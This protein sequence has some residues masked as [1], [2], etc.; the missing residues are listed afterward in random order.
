MLALNPSSDHGVKLSRG[1]PRAPLGRW[2]RAYSPKISRFC[3]CLTAYTVPIPSWLEP[4]ATLP[5]KRLC[6][7]ENLSSIGAGEMGEVYA[8]YDTVWTESSAS[9]VLPS[10][11]ADNP[12]Q[13]D[14]EA[15]AIFVAQA[16]APLHADGIL[17]GE[18]PASRLERCHCGSI[19]G[20]V[21]HRGR[22][23]IGQGLPD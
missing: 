13:F 2:T 7:Y 21:R 11:L 15:R 19:G 12:E 8:A 9:K 10:H 14:R 20:A 22:G 3:D 1:R 17:G 23:W 5:D 4:V 18:A 6:P 16:P